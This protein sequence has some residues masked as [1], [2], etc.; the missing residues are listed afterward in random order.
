MADVIQKKCDFKHHPGTARERACGKDVPGNEPTSFTVGGTIYESDLCEEHQETLLEDL[1][2]YT[3]IARQVRRRYGKS[4]RKAVQ[5][6]GGAF[7]TK[8]V[9]NWLREQGRE[10]SDTGRISEDII[11]EFMKT[12]S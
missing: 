10:V 1:E 7:T 6:R 8:D 3:S 5:G 11:K 9:R 12:H 4:V 2:P